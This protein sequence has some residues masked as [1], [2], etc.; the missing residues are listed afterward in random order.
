[1]TDVYKKPN[2][3]DMVKTTDLVPVLEY[4][5]DFKKR[6]SNIP[7]GKILLLLEQVDSYKFI[8]LYNNKK[9][10]YDHARYIALGGH[11][12]PFSVVCT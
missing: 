10:A 11:W 8:F 2:P 3:G 1:M 6:N 4:I 12:Y 9:W 5:D 7:C